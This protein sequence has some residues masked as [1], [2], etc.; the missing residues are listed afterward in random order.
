MDF[1]YTKD[2]PTKIHGSE[3]N[4]GW[5]Q[6]RIFEGGPAPYHRKQIVISN[7]DRSGHVLHIILESGIDQ[8]GQ[9]GP[10]RICAVFPLTNFT[11]LTS[12]VVRIRNNGLD[13]DD[14]TTDQVAIP[15]RVCET[16]YL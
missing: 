6:E 7:E 16:F 8:D 5:N 12:G 13:L 3:F 14:G 2:A 1:A 4:L 10:T 11:L 9:G 15:V